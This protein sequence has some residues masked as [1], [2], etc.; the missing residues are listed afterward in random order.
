MKNMFRGRK[1]V[2]R[3]FKPAKPFTGMIRQ[4]N[5]ETLV[6]VS[7]DKFDAFKQALE[8]ADI[9]YDLGDFFGDNIIVMK[10]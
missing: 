2:K 3:A 9:D 6:L 5:K 10:R 8:E 4:L 1:T 7:L